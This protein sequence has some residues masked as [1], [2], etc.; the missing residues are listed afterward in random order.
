MMGT[1]FRN[2][3]GVFYALF[4]GKKISLSFLEWLFKKYCWCAVDG[5]Y[6][7][8]SVVYF[9]LLCIVNTASGTAATFVV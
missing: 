2:F 6:I 5:W 3:S 4:N 7:K 9:F 8:I 1:L